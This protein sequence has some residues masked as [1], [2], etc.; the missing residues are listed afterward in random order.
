MGERESSARIYGRGDAVPE[1]PDEGL[2]RQ[3]R[4]GGVDASTGDAAKRSSAQK[5]KTPTTAAYGMAYMTTT[6]A[7]ALTASFYRTIR[8]NPQMAAVAAEARNHILDGGFYTPDLVDAS[9]QKWERD[10]EI[11]LIDA[12]GFAHIWAHYLHGDIAY[13]SV[14][15]SQSPGADREVEYNQSILDQL[16]EGF[17]AEY[18]PTKGRGADDDGSFTI[19][20]GIG[21]WRTF[22]TGQNEQRD[23]QWF[24]K[25]DH[26]IAL[27]VGTTSVS[28]TLY[29]LRCRRGVARWPYG[30]N[31]IIVLAGVGTNTFD[32]AVARQAKK[33]PDKMRS[34]KGLVTR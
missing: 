11:T 34:V 30:Y 19:E 24:F 8:E 33:E 4:D 16:P 22:R 17:R 28:K 1:Q 14:P 2:D 6:H 5:E 26:T 32:N 9:F 27:E 7:D 15:L 20:K 10:K 13:C 3:N 12:F 23:E 21:L 25:E 29:H 18:S 31:K